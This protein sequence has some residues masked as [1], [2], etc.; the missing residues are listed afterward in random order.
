MNRS[1]DWDVIWRWQWFRRALWQ[2]YFRD[3]SHPEGRTA[4][5]TPVWTGILQQ[6]DAK[7]VLDCQCGLGLRTILLHEA[8]FDVVGTDASLVAVQH[9][10]ELASARDLNIPFINC[11]WQDL[12]EHFGAEFDAIVN[13]AWAWTL[14][15]TEL[16]FAAHNFASILRPGGVLIFTGADQWSRPED[17]AT[18]VENAWQSAPRFQLRNDYEHDNTHLT[19]VVARDKAEIGVVENYLFI[20]SDESGPRLETAAICNSTEWTWDDFQHVCR[21]AGFISLE[22]AKVPVGRREHVFNIAKK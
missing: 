16:R 9:A 13:D 20:V 6:H 1:E 15:R 11:A 3:A 5:S 10:R 14:N 8:G 4:R 18:L 22:S 2:P 12:G 21:E 7:R 17:R 19:L